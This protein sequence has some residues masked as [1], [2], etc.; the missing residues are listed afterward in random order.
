MSVAVLTI[1]VAVVYM[2]RDIIMLMWTNPF[3]GSLEEVGP[4]DFRLSGPTPSNGPRNGFA[5][6]KVHKIE[7]FFG[8]DFEICIISL[9]VM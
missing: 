8:F 7:I 2:A 1:S 4:K 5:P 9:L 3:R 6:L